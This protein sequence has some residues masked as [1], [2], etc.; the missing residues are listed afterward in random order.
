MMGITVAYLIGIAE[1]DVICITEIIMNNLGKVGWID[2]QQLGH[3]G[4]I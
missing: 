4:L 1:T 3:D 2:L